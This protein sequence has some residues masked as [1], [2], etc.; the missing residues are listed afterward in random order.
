[1]ENTSDSGS[2]DSC[3]SGMEILGNEPESSSQGILHMDDK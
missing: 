1:M 2:N 3:Y